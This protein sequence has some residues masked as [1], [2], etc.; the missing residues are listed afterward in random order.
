MKLGRT[1]DVANDP[2]WSDW[3]N[4]NARDLLDRLVNDLEPAAFSISSA[5]LSF[6][7]QAERLLDRPVRM[8][9]SGSSLFTLYDTENEADFAQLRLVH[10]GHFARAEAVELAPDFIDDL[11]TNRP[12]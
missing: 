9:G 10:D 7:Q 3:S 12:G 2:D 1:A 11:N 5:L 8:S 4:L 6:H